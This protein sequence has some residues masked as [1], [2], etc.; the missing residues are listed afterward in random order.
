[1]N[2]IEDV[3]DYILR[4]FFDSII[5]NSEIIEIKGKYSEIKNLIKDAIFQIKP[6][7]LPSRYFQSRVIMGYQAF[8]ELE[9]QMFDV[10]YKDK[11]HNQ[12]P[13]I[14]GRDIYLSELLENYIFIIDLNSLTK[15]INYKLNI[16]VKLSE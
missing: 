14:F 5:N 2:S 6:N 9:K 1:M 7:Y 12:F 8:N 16:K 4:N 11:Y 10:Y 15:D 3:K 13:T